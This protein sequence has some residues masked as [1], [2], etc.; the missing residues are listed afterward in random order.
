[1]SLIEDRLI[2]LESL[3][4]ESGVHDPPVNSLVHACVMEAV[5]FAAGEPW[6]DHPEC[7]SPVIGCSCARGMTRSGMKTGRG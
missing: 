6:S 7:A 3:R 4:L 2:C 5:A 1:V